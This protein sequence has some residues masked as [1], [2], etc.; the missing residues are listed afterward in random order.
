MCASVSSVT[1][2]YLAL[3][4]QRELRAEK[5]LTG[6]FMEEADANYCRELRWIVLYKSGLLAKL[7]AESITRITQAPVNKTRCVDAINDLMEL[8]E[9]DQQQ[10]QKPR[11]SRYGRSEEIQT[12]S[13]G[14]QQ[15]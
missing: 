13:F 6:K 9:K 8:Y 14:V 4:W 7:P 3:K 1:S 10:R 5:A 15:D 2:G 11:S 12:E